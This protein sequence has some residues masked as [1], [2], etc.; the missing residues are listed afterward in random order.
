MYLDLTSKQVLKQPDYMYNVHP[1]TGLKYWYDCERF[2]VTRHLIL[3][4]NAFYWNLFENKI[5][6]GLAKILFPSAYNFN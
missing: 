1:K 4:S 3:F 2:C 6:F 5:G